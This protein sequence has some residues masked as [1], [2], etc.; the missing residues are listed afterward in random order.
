M[1]KGTVYFHRGC[2]FHDGE[3]GDKLFIILNNPRTDEYF[4]T[5]KTTSQQKW[6]SER[7]GCH[8]DD[9]YYVL[10]ENDDFFINRTW[11][12]FHEYYPRT[13][14]FIQD[15]VN[16]GIITKKTDLREQTI[17]AIINCA[18]QSDDISGLYKAMINR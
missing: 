6:R 7:E 8:S 2:R 15:Y 17:R 5:C 14:Q 18:S 12:Q 11:V 4:I 3:I 13:Q 1:K 9:N 16:R 10:R